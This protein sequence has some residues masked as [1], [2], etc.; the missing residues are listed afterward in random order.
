MNEDFA[1]LISDLDEKNRERIA[2]AL[3][4]TLTN[5]LE[6]IASEI[7]PEFE[8]ERIKRAYLDELMAANGNDNK[9]ERAISKYRLLGEHVGLRPHWSDLN[10]LG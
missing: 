1:G 10:K 9:I 8:R 2:A 5:E 7:S 4:T 6:D 3:R